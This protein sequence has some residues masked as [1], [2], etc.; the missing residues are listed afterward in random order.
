MTA[1]L[2]GQQRSFATL[3]ISTQELF[4]K[5][6]EKRILDRPRTGGMSTYVPAGALSHTWTG[7]ILCSRANWLFN[8]NYWIVSQQ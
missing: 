4:A 5:F 8:I 1:H 3:H 6:P 7:T 2:M